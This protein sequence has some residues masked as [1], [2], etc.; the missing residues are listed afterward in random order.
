MKPVA[1][2]VAVG[3][4]LAIAPGAIAQPGRAAGVRSRTDGATAHATP[5]TALPGP[6]SLL[7]HFGVDEAARLMRSA[8]ADERIRGVERAAATRT[9]EAL[10][11]LERV[12]GGRGA[13]GL[14]P[15]LPDAGMARRDPRA[16]LAVVHGLASW[17]ENEGA[18]AALEDLVVAPIDALAPRTGSP[19]AH[20]GSADDADG[21]QRV[22]LARQEAAIAL[23]GSGN[24]IALEHL[25]ADARSGGVAQEA[26]LIGLSIDPPSDP[27]AL[28][29]VALTTPSTI[30]LAIKVGDLRT[31]DAILGVMRASDPALRAAA[32][33]GLG[34]AGDTRAAGL[35]RAALQDSDE[36]VRVA[37]VEAL[38]RL[39]TPDAAAAVEALIG[40]ESTA[41]EGLRIAEDV[42]GEGV[43]KAAAARAAAT[44]DPAL[45]RAAMAVLGRQTTPLAVRALV[46]LAAAP[47]SRGDALGE[48]ARSPSPAALEALEE[49]GAG[50]GGETGG[51]M[52]TADSLGEPIAASRRLAARA[53]FV[54]RFVSGNRS[55]RLD[56]L[57]EG[58]AQSRDP[59]D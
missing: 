52:V 49:M 18:R 10:A 5:A 7:G 22:T 34:A 35:A 6:N 26:A 50:G 17:M 32:L 19:G 59:R 29:G 55:R 33:R 51:A 14:D 12:A 25:V 27:V 23:A 28:G 9:L 38:A 3:M 47:Q 54:R 36:R 40:D 53:Y 21:A 42:Q 31:L 2:V 13:S 48:L 4:A 20:D 24:P 41:L 15:R 8:D 37:A 56:A 46:A 16:L 57:L 44:A 45:R 39:V 11:L 1:A 30:A 58:L 43:T